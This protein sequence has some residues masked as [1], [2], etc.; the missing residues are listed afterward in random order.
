MWNCT[1]NNNFDLKLQ[2]LTNRNNLTLPIPFSRSHYG[3]YSTPIHL[4]INKNIP[5]NRTSDDLNK[6]RLEHFPVKLTL[7]LHI[8]LA[9]ISNPTKVH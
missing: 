3:R 6:K 7:N 4:A 1:R 9:L 8:A 5:Y 2:H